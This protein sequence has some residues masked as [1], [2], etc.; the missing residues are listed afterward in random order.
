MNKV[1]QWQR[2]ANRMEDQLSSPD[3]DPDERE[4][5]ERALANYDERVGNYESS[6]S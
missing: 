4:E 6:S 3:L 5:I 1:E 2:E